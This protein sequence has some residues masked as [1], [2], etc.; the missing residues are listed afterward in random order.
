[1]LPGIDA[2]TRYRRVDRAVE[3][4]RRIRAPCAATF[5]AKCDAVGKFTPQQQSNP[6]R[7]RRCDKG[8]RFSGAVRE[9][10]EIGREKSAPLSD[11]FMGKSDLIPVGCK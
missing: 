1:M 2:F 4:W 5:F 10:T 9:T 3:R 6:L 7:A 8:I 11:G